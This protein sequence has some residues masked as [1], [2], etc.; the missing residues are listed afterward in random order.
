MLT[1]NAEDVLAL[2]QE[3]MGRNR[4][5]SGILIVYRENN[6]ARDMTFQEIADALTHIDES[7]IPLEN[8][9]HNL[10]R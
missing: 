3:W 6:P 4:P 8:A 9:C 5:H 10:N 1:A 2:H 7:A